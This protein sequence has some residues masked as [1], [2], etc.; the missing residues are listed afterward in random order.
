M[1]EVDQAFSQL[2]TKVGGLGKFLKP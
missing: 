2:W 1:S